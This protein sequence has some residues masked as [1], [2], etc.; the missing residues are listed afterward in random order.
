M[1]NSMPANHG[2]RYRAYREEWIQAEAFCGVFSAFGRPHQGRKGGVWRLGTHV[3]SGYCLISQ[4]EF[5]FDKEWICFGLV[6]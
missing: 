1:R 2:E 6:N 4:R 3:L 5:S